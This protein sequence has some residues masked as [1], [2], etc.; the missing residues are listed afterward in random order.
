MVFLPS[1]APKDKVPIDQLGADYPPVKKQ[2]RG[3]IEYN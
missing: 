2:R 3:I 1:L